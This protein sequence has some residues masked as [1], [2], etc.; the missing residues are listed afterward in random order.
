MLDGARRATEGAILATEAAIDRLE[1]GEDK[2]PAR[3]GANLC[4][5][6]SVDDGEAAGVAEPSDADP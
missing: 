6:W 1:S 2:D 5:G 4:D 3:T